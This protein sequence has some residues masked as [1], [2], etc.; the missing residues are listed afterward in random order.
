MFT[1]NTMYCCGYLFSQINRLSLEGEQQKTHICNISLYCILF[2]PLA[3]LFYTCFYIMYFI[4]GDKLP[5]EKKKKVLEINPPSP[6]I[7][8]L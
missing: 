2:Q 1:V 6:R 7:L 5:I 4:L 8:Y 3:P